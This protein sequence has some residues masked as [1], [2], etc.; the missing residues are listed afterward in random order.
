LDRN[1]DAGTAADVQP[2]RRLEDRVEEK[3]AEARWDAELTPADRL[4]LG[5]A[6]R[7]ETRRLDGQLSVYAPGGTPA[8]QFQPTHS[9]QELGLR[10]LY[11]E[12]SHRANDRL[13]FKLGSY[14]DEPS[15]IQALALPKVV[16][17][18]QPAGQSYLVFLAYPITATDATELSPV[19]TWAQPLGF[20]LLGMTDSGWTMSYELH[21]ERP[22]SR[23]SLLSL[24]AFLRDAHGLLLDLE[25]PRFA[26]AP[27]RLLVQRAW[28]RG[29]LASIEQT[30]AG[31]LSV[32]L[33]AQYQST[34]DRLTSRELPTF[35]PWQG[36][37][38]LDYLD[39]AGWR[40][41]LA[42]TYVGRRFGDA[43]NQKRLGGVGVL[44]LR[45]ARQLDL[46]RALFVQIN[47]LLDRSYESYIGYPQP[48]RS[49][50]GG[51]EYRF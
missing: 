45:I 40:G 22:M 8:F 6:W 36:G 18:Y 31:P 13:E 51:V 19:E 41:F 7:G 5:F 48:G 35:A 33:F 28:V 46:R 15:G 23:L 2:Y 17:R 30:L 47:N 20:D 12:W 21:Y 24:S 43:A 26:P 9:R 4:T 50:Q 16:A 10:T 49:I 1:P 14:V 32:R 27:N 44:D 34:Q 42:L 39:R 3:L 11:G 38:R 25:D 29:G 37:A